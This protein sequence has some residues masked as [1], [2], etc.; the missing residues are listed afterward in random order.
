MVPIQNIYFLLC[1]AWDRLDALDERWVKDTPEAPLLGMLANLLLVQTDRLVRTGLPQTYEARTASLSSLRGR[2]LP[3]ESRRNRLRHR[4]QCEFDELS[5][6]SLFNQVLQSTLKRLSRTE[7]LPQGQKANA[8]AL[9]AYFTQVRAL[10]LAPFHFSELRQ[11]QLAPPAELLVHIGELLFESSLPTTKEGRYRF[12]DF[13]R[14][15]RKMAALFEAFC[16]SFFRHESHHFQVSREHIQWQVEAIDI[17]TQSLFPRMETDISLISEEKKIIMDAKFYPEA[18]ASN[19]F[20]TAKFRPPH[21]YQMFAYLKNVEAKD[22]LSLTA[23]GILLYPTA[24]P[25]R[26]YDFQMEGHE[27]S[28][29]C[30]N[31]MQDWKGIK[32]D[33]LAFLEK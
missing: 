6:D 21:L 33:L 24:A 10:E 25:S 29:C 15:E 19:R 18:L 1:Y 13:R 27:L 22:I 9:S 11:K 28:I 31:L 14:D 8:I 26:R 20:G 2:I 5:Q 17:N 30:I 32:R 12:A 16:R 3:L 23:K 4:M 7:D